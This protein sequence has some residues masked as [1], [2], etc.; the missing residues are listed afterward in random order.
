MFYKAL[1]LISSFSFLVYSFRS[2]FSRAMIHEYSR[3]GVKN[4]RILIVLLQLIG[5]IG[6]LLG[7]YNLTLLFLSS[8]L[9]TIM[10]I[11][12]IFVRI[13]IKDSIIETLP[14]IFYAIL[15]FIIFFNTCLNVY[16]FKL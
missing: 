5:S 14:A 12:A 6:L 10:M 16:I 8:F 13:N 7:I 9:L 2:I 1:I 15:N 4:L 3:W 11:F